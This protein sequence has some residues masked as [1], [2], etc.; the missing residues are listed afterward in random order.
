MNHIP[1]HFI[2]DALRVAYIS[3]IRALKLANRLK[4]KLASKKHRSRI[5]SRLNRIRAELSRVEKSAITVVR[6]KVTIAPEGQ[7]MAYHILKRWGIV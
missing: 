3:A 6:P 1:N 2:I 4:C 7:S 5:M